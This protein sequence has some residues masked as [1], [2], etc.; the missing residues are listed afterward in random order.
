MTDRTDEQG[1][2][3]DLYELASQP[4]DDPGTPAWIEWMVDRLH[5]RSDDASRGD[6]DQNTHR[7]RDMNAMIERPTPAL[8]DRAEIAP[9]HNARVLTE[10]GRKAQIQLDD[11]VYSLMITRAGKLI[12][13]K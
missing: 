2:R 10:G 8:D 9:L 1:T 6:R 11:K 3:F 13:T 4:G 5:R 12:L 7:G